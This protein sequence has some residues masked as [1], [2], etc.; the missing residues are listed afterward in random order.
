MG[1]TM[2]SSPGEKGRE[3]A[4]SASAGVQPGVARQCLTPSSR[5]KACSN[6]PVMSEE[7]PVST[8]SCRYFIAFG[9]IVRG[10]G[11]GSSPWKSKKA[12][13]PYLALSTTVMRCSFGS[14]HTVQIAVGAAYQYLHLG[15]AVGITDDRHSQRRRKGQFP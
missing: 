10:N 7:R 3:A 11:L 8:T 14:F 12:A 1:L 15:V 9:P 5:A 6:R 2:I 13:A 4:S